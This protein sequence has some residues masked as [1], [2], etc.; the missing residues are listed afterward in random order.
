MIMKGLSRAK[1]R[2]FTLIERL[3]VIA[4]I[5]ILA[6]II[7]VA[8]NNARQRA[9]QASGESTLSSIT[10]AA[11]L[12]F[13]ENPPVPLNVP[14]NANATCVGSTSLW[15]VHADNAGGTVWSTGW[16]AITLNA[17]DAAA[18]TFNYSATRPGVGTFTCTQSGCTRS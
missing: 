7:L 16:G 15:P 8:L 2:G 11:N 6:V 12:C 14:G 5:A 9:Q 4:I 18:G 17:Q 1:S 3:V 13:S 10:A